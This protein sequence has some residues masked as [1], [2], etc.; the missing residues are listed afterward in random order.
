ME[1]CFVHT[2]YAWM[3]GMWVELHC[4]G[5]INETPE[6]CWLLSI[7]A[8][9]CTIMSRLNQVVFSNT[10]EIPGFTASYP[11]LPLSL[12]L[13]LSS[14]FLV[15]LAEDYFSVIIVFTFQLRRH[16]SDNFW[17]WNC[18]H[19]KSKSLVHP[20]GIEP[21]T[22]CL[23]DGSDSDELI[24]LQG[25]LLI[26][27]LNKKYTGCL[28]NCLNHSYKLR[29]KFKQHNWAQQYDTKNTSFLSDH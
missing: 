19:Q 3:P 17:G 28:K 25:E 10:C 2:R 6:A 26:H 20:P 16:S 27:S 18:D 5:L 29:T 9:G 14:Y 13:T 1:L 8:L 21:V 24:A 22:F 12:S 23:W 7:E 4:R 15:V 11:V